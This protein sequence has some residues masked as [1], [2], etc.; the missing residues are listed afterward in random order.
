MSRARILADYSGS[1]VTRAKL[2]FLNAETGTANSSTFLRG[3]KSWQIADLTPSIVD[4]GNTTAITIDSNETVTLAG[5]LVVSG[6]Q[7]TVNSTTL[8]VD[9][10]NIELGS[11]DTPSDTTADG[12]GITLKGATDK[13][14]NWVDS[15]DAW[16]SSEHINLASGKTFQLNG[17]SISASATELNLL[18]GVTS[19][20][21]ELNLLDGVTSTTTELNLLDG[22]TATTA[23][24]NY[25]DISALGTA[26]VGK[27]VTSSATGD[28]TFVDSTND[29]DIASH[30][31]TN[32][33]KLG[34]TLVTATAAELNL[35]DGK[36]S[37]GSPSITDNGNATAITIDSSERAGIGITDPDSRLEVKDKIKVSST[38]TNP[39]FDLDN[40]TTN[41]KNWRMQAE[42]GDGAFTFKNATD[43]T[44][45]YQINTAGEFLGLDVSGNIILTGS[46]TASGT[47]TGSNL[48]G[49]NTGDQTL[50]TDFVSAASG[51][52]FS[53]DVVINN[54]G[55]S[56]ALKINNSGS[57]ASID[58]WSTSSYRNIVEFASSTHQPAFV[59]T[60]EA[61]VGIN[62][63][64][65][66]SPL[67][68][69]GEG[70]LSVHNYRTQFVINNTTADVGD[71]G[72][73]YR[74]SD[75]ASYPFDEWGN[76]ILQGSTTAGQDI[77]FAT[78]T[79]SSV[80]MKIDSSQHMYVTG[81]VTSGASD[82]RLK[83]NI[84]PINNAVEKVKQIKGITFD[85]IN[86]IEEIVG[87]PWNDTTERHVGVLAQD[88][89]KILPE[90]IRPAPFDVGG[91]KKS[92]SGK[93]YLTVKYE[94]LV[95]LLI[96]AIKEQQ[97]QID[98]LKRK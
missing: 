23:E 16:T 69:A 27:V 42:S 39:L 84:E 78:G 97:V 76:L 88:V 29:I 98:D 75:G 35:L 80:A 48:S 20:T 96:E 62:Y 2:D 52:T 6:T 25:N 36:T 37:V 81:D 82:E 51:G 85:W 50:P 1:G 14:F 15:T 56:P 11:V 79:I 8:T 13:T 24:L 31:G 72:Y 21:T 44:T 90:V 66:K 95:P 38:T 83:E 4:G 26:E 68:I 63:T 40:Q 89:Q 30:D 71:A 32:G 70:A 47:V 87:S 59:V 94:H 5:N 28:V 61:F 34:G 12:G 53:D 17:T 9:D 49:T 58:V 18:D 7:T 57:D 10:K 43:N 41:G 74:S 22:V 91:H 3:D 73:I 54:A 33:L 92:K 86:N 65:P 19:T 46:V 45:A 64:F 60:K 77:V 55:S 93:N 67:H